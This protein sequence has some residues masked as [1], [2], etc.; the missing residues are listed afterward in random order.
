MMI[1]RVDDTLVRR[2]QAILHDVG[3][4]DAID[5]GIELETAYQKGL[6]LK[7]RMQQSEAVRSAIIDLIDKRESEL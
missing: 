2:L 5:L 6:D 7:R 4:R 1:L 3:T